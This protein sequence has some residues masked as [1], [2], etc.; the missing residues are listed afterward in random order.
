M[1]SDKIVQFVSFETSLPTDLFIKQWE[2]YTRSE[3]NDTEVTLQQSEKK[4]VFKYIAQ[5]RR[6]SGEFQF[7]FSKAGRSSRVPEVEIKAKQ[8][9]GYAVLQEERMTDTIAGESKLFAFITSPTA[10]LQPY[11]ILPERGKLNIYEAYFENCQ[12]AYVLE[13]FVKNSNVQVLTDI[14]KTLN[15]TE[16]GV[17][18]ECE[19]HAV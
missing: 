5:Y 19:L 16:L 7:L 4:G 12:Y 13:F 14:L 10:D 9:G 6:T 1:R 3:K 17:Y 15:P 8:A 2:Q 11:K 18:T